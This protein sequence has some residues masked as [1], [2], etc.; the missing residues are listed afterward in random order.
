[1]NKR[2]FNKEL[3]RAV[4]KQDLDGVKRILKQGKANSKKVKAP[5]KYNSHIIM[6]IIKLLSRK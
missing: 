2:D 1:M 6:S 3:M 4:Q 5:P